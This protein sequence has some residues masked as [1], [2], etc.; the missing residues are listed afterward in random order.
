MRVSYIYHHDHSLL[1]P[2][3]ILLKNNILLHNH[4]IIINF[5][6]SNTDTVFYLIYW[7]YAIFFS[8]LNS[9]FT[10]LFAPPVQDP[11]LESG[12]A[13]HC[14]VSSASF[15]LAYLQSLCLLWYWQFWRIKSF[16]KNRTFLIL[17]LSDVSSWLDSGYVSL[18]G[19]LPEQ[20]WVLLRASQKHMIAVCPSVIVLIPITL[21]RCYPV[22]LLC[23]YCYFP[24]K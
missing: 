23:A 2:W 4:S 24:C 1:I 21:T 9:V 12:I 3:W 8:W 18:A 6:K 17:G 11:V 7:L 20:C 16:K 15:N 19:K 14:H 10:A 22:S 5:S 13:F